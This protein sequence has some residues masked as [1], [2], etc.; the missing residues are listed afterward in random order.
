MK[1]AYINVSNFVRWIKF[2]F[3]RFKVPREELENE[4][5]RKERIRS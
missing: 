2:R 5:G 3:E 1:K 4:N